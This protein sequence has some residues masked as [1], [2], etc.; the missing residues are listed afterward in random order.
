MILNL[1]YVVLPTVSFRRSF[2]FFKLMISWI[3]YCL[4]LRLYL[5]TRSP[6]SAVWSF[7][8]RFFGQLVAPSLS[9]HWQEEHYLSYIA[10]IFEFPQG[11]TGTT[12]QADHLQKGASYLLDAGHWNTLTIS[13]ARSV[14]NDAS[15][16]LESEGRVNQHLIL[17]HQELSHSLPQLKDSQVCVRLS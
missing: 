3:E 1:K 15:P 5:R 7:L 10:K 11:W 9:S 12:G 8:C 16:K 6:M 14:G 17:S 4:R 13:A 2:R